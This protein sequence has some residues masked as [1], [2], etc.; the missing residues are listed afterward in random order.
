[1]IYNMSKEM[2]YKEIYDNIYKQYL[3]KLHE[4]QT[5]NVIDTELLDPDKFILFRICIESFWIKINLN[6]FVTQP[7]IHIIGNTPLILTYVDKNCSDVT[8]SGYT[9]SMDCE[10]L[11]RNYL[12]DQ[13]K[14]ILQDEILNMLLGKYE[15]LNWCD[16]NSNWFES[17]KENKLTL[18]EIAE[19]IKEKNWEK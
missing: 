16:F 8:L 3:E 14:Y 5:K 12:D 7:L 9:L 11:F 15:Y 2:T 6:T 13:I 17:F 4:L 18:E 19:I 1:M 10:N